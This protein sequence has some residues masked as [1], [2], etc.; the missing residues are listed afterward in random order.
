MPIN[1]L[2]KKRTFIGN[3]AVLFAH[4]HLTVV[5]QVYAVAVVA[6]A[7]GVFYCALQ[8]VQPLRIVSAR[9]GYMV[10]AAL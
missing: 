2:E 6:V 4:Y 5:G 10:A 8:Y 7:S 1:G 9:H 3:R